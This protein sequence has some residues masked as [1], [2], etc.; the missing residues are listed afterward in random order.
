MFKVSSIEVTGF[1][2]TKTASAT[3]RDD[4]NIIIGKN[5]TGKMT[6]PPPA[7]PR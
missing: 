2:Q 5:G 7:V 3:F 4:V 1:W 6:C